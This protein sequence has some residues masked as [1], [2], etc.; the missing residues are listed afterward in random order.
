MKFNVNSKNEEDPQKNYTYDIDKNLEWADKF[1]KNFNDIYEKLGQS[2][3][4]KNTKGDHKRYIAFIFRPENTFPCG[5]LSC[6]VYVEQPYDLFL[7]DMK[8]AFSII[9]QKNKE[10]LF[11]REKL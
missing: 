2:F 5:N 7:K 6:C 8:K 11:N 3:Y 4:I 9:Y 1:I 10:Y